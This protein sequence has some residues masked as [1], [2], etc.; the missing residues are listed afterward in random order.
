MST[1][2]DDL[3]SGIFSLAASTIEGMKNEKI[4]NQ[5]R[6]LKLQLESIHTRKNLD[7][8]SKTVFRARDEERQKKVILFGLTE[9]E[10]EE[11]SGRI[12]D[13]L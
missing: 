9:R 8:I 11:L 12:E 7:A 10:E 5:G 13:I 6:V 2:P 1:K 3:S 4:S